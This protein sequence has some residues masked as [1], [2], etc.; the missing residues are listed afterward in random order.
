MEHKAPR[1]IQQILQLAVN[2][3]QSSHHQWQVPG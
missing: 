2:L 1:K 3:T